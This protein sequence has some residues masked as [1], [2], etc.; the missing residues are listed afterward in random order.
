MFEYLQTI[1]V[2]I[3][4]DRIKFICVIIYGDKIWIQE[5]SKIFFAECRGQNKFT[6]FFNSQPNGKSTICHN[7]YQF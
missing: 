6:E 7:I 2:F 1:K 3:C 4:Q 5:L